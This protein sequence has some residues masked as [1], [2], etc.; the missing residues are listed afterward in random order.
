VSTLK[1]SAE[2]L[3]LNADGSGNDIKFQSNATEVAAI[4][5]AGNLTLSG[6]VDGVDIQTLNTAV[7]ANTAKVTNSTSASDLTSGTLPMAR[8]SGTLPALN[9]SALTNI[10]AAT[11]STTAPS[12]PAQGDMWFDSTAGIT[13]MK[14]YSGTAWDQLSNKFS[15][16]GGTESTYTSGGTIYKVHTFTSSGTFTAESSGS[17]DVLVVAGGGGGGCWVAGGGGAG[18]MI[19]R[20]G[21]S[22]TAGAKTVTI[23][24][25]GTGG[26]NPGNYGGMP[27]G[28][29]GGNSSVLG[30]TALG[31][32]LGS[33]WDQ[34]HDVNGGS[35]GGGAVDVSAPNGLGLQPSQSGDSGT[36]GYGNNGGGKA[37]TP[38]GHGATGG[39]GAGAAATNNKN[40]GVGKDN[41]YRTGS[42]IKYAGG[43]GAGTHDAGYGT[44]S[45][46]AGGGGAG[47]SGSAGP[48]QNGGT[49][50]GGGA[51]GSG[52]N[53][54]QASRGG[55]G[56]SGIVI[57]RYAV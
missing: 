25:G 5:Q 43:G 22:I 57:V 42:N 54:G 48:G 33:M 30:L 31:G 20:P 6:T 40:G 44:T 13:A 1:S 55:N 50:L 53:G 7:A 3:T 8:L 47:Y 23:G 35:G 12:S 10:D 45:G 15:A 46:G 14:V 39:G 16:T 56:G 37:G 4:D 28:T 38:S 34:T 41:N 11:V 32:G 29:V 52:N 36:Y 18:G 19:I 51:G 26:Y 27:N 49:N 9:G 24:A 2:H 21:L 17:V